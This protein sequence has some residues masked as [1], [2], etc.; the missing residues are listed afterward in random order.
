MGESI[1]RES[2]ILHLLSEHQ[3]LLFVAGS[4]LI[5]AILLALGILVGNR[6]ERARREREDDAEVR[7]TRD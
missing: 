5:I 2:D 3:F 7:T 4:L 6:M 1:E